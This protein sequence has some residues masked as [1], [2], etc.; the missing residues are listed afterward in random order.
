MSPSP[1][2]V[3]RST[4]PV[5]AYA[6]A[7]SEALSSCLQGAQAR[8]DKLRSAG[9]ATTDVDREIL[10]LRRQLREGGR[11]RPGDALGDGRYL[12]VRAVG[13][14]GFAVVWQAY[15]CA[16]HV[17]VAIKVLHA[18]LAGDPLRR[19]RFFR[20]ARAMM[21]LTHSAVVRVLMPEG[22]DG[23]FYYFVMEFVPGGNLR[24]AVLAQCVSPGNLLSIIIQVGDGLALAHSTGMIHRD[25]KPANILLDEHGNAKLTDF[26]LVG[27]PDTTG[28]TLTGTLGTVVYAAPECLEM[29]QKATA[30][31]DVFGLGMT[32]LFCLSQRELALSTF[33]DPA[34][35]LDQLNCSTAVRNVIRRAVAW[36]PEQRFA[37]AFDMMTEFRN[38][39][40]PA[41][42]GRDSSAPREVGF[43]ATSRATILKA[44]MLALVTA[45]S[46]AVG[47]V[48]IA[49]TIRARTQRELES[50]IAGQVH[51][52]TVAVERARH[53][54]QQRDG[55]R[56]R[57][58]GLFDTQHW[59]EGESVWEEAEMLA[60]KEASEYRTA[61]AHL[62]D[63][64]SL[65]PT[66][67]ELR[68]Q[69]ADLTFE[70]LPRAERDRR[71]ELA[72]ELAGRLAAYDTARLHTA[73]RPSATVDLEVAPPGTRV[74]I[75]RGDRS[76]A[77]IEVTPPTV[78]LP[79]ESAVLVFQAPGHVTA[80][81]PVLAARGETLTLRVALPELASAPPGMLYVPAGRFLFGGNEISDAWRQALNTVPLHEVSTAAYYIGQYE[82]TFGEWIAYLDE[83]PPEERR[84]RTPRSVSAPESV[85]P[86]SSVELNEL[87]PRRW[88]LSLRPTT[89]TY[90]AET[91][92]RLRYERRTRRTDQDWTR[93]PVSGVS[94]D[95]ANSYAAWLDRTGRIPGARLCDE[96]EWERAARGADARLF[97]SG[98]TLAPDDA[99]IDSTY[100]REPLAF[101]PDEV[102]SHPASRSPIGADDMAG[103]AW[104]WTRSVRRSGAPAF[105][106]GSW[107]QGEITAQSQNREDG[108]PM[109]R[110][111]MIGLR[112]CATPR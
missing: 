51:E 107:Y 15:D 73:F 48:A 83:L 75:E 96:Y 18:S 106:G 43:R 110:G 97:P 105:R 19:E 88:R 68:A 63:A 23:G 103:N 84:R 104:E 91:G 52:A 6:D 62:E 2:Q 100:G 7:E 10:E 36:D 101:G 14:G 66:R 41:A 58:F 8:R 77:P 87:A 79:L 17:H 57:A 25:I 38:V 59:T 44:R 108:E 1:A 85:S 71:G 24:E 99:N 9:I 54:A 39:L 76:G 22:E 53:V 102:G 60:A 34:P 80:R 28:G 42:L 26:D 46:L 37:N 109:M 93:F 50:V 94:F 3:S 49:L 72:D 64:L 40:H 11:L 13:R 78:T 74:W 90:T 92:Q 47:V 20:G 30:R 61:S 86:A 21:K 67:P 112:L 4:R 12:L 95:D 82:V 33:R 32:A 65:D 16:S 5:P 70:R 81:L 31:A 27:V 35:A 89:Q 111:P 29:P 98:A 45:A 56:A 55:A 69:F